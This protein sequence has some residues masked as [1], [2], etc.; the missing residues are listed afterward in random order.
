MPLVGV[1]MGSSSDEAVV[2]ETVSVLDQMGI[3]TRLRS[4]PRTAPLRRSW[5]MLPARAA[6]AS[7][8]S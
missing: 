8:C 2:A 5:S 3:E 7:K 6:G 4:H 1:I